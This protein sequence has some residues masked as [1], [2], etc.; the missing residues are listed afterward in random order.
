MFRK[1]YQATEARLRHAIRDCGSSWLGHGS[2][3]PGQD[4]A[5]PMDAPEAALADARDEILAAREACA[6]SGKGGL[7]QRPRG[8]HRLAQMM[9]FSRKGRPSVTRL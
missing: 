1:D 2:D 4:T 5:A 6:A 9:A 7:R 8:R 3:M